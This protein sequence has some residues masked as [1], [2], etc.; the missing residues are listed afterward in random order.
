MTSAFDDCKLVDFK[1]DNVDDFTSRPSMFKRID[2]NP[3]FVGLAKEWRKIRDL[4]HQL[5][6]HEQ[7]L[8]KALIGLA[9]GHNVKGGGIIIEKII[10]R[11]NI[12]Y[13]MIPELSSLDLEKFRKPS[14]ESYRFTVE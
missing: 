6:E 8:R 7:A 10:R 5:T 2:D 3:S 4:I 11:G 12:D 14:T 9:E 13:G 1:M